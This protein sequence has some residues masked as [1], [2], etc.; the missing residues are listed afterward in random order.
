[1]LPF[2]VLVLTS[3]NQSSFNIFWVVTIQ[4]TLSEELE[5]FLL[6]SNFTRGEDVGPWHV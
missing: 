4:Q 1:M 2:L 3:L 6:M 5:V